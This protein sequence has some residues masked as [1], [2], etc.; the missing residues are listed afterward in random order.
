[1][2]LVT[3]ATSGIGQAVCDRLA[4]DSGTTVIATYFSNRP[5]AV[6]LRER[7]GR[8]RCLITRVDVRST[9]HIDRLFDLIEQRFGALHALVA[10]ASHSRAKDWDADPLSLSLTDWR[11]SLSVDLTGAYICMRKAVPLIRTSGGGSIVAFSSAGALKGDVDTFCYNS[12]KAGLNAV[13][14]SFARE[15]APAIRTNQIAPGSIDTGWVERWGLADDDVQRLEALNTGMRRMGRP[16]E[17]AAAVSFLLSEEAS[18][19]NGQ[20]LFLD[21]GSSH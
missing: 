10:A 8:G 5:A 4:E 1:M 3:G 15:Y 7:L 6:A 20:T 17:V 14:Q 11:D 13:V 12:A 18:Y 9:S 16:S 2:V 21:G 19:L